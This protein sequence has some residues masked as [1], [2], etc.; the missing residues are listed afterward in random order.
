MSRYTKSDE[1]THMPFLIKDDEVLEKII[2]VIKLAIV[3][4]KD[5]IANQY[6]IKNM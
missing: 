2:S 3:L 1:T 5:L 6:T 4:K